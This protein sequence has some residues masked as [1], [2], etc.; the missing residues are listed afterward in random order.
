MTIEVAVIPVLALLVIGFLA[1]LD[2]SADARYEV[3]AFRVHK[4]SF[5][6]GER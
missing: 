2:M 3:G 4:R 6:R 5:V 1:W